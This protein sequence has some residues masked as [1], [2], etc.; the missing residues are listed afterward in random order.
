M[1]S[2]EKQTSYIWE[3]HNEKKNE[4]LKMIIITFKNIF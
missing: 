2:K 3:P 4:C 1:K